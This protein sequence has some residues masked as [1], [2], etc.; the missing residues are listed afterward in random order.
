M[1]VLD[2]S[3]I[4]Q[5]LNSLRELMRKHGVTHYLVPSADPHQSEYVPA[6]WRR[7]EAISGFT[8]SAGTAVVGLESA[9]LWTDSRYHLQAEKELDPAHYTVLREGA[10]GVP[11]FTE[12]LQGAAEGGSVGVDPRVVSVAQERTWRAAAEARGGRF[13]FVDENLIDAAWVGKPATSKAPL[14][15][16]GVEFSGEAPAAKLARVEADED[17]LPP[18]DCTVELAEIPEFRPDDGV[19]WPQPASTA[20]SVSASV[21]SAGQRK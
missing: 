8:G 2:A 13:L 12:W 6:W 18:L 11:K 16:L 10:P 14:R 21:P 4:S 3:A 15:P 20:V 9:W 5:R 19:S 17:T 7:R 1:P